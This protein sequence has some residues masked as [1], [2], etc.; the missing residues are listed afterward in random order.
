MTEGFES[1]ISFWLD[2]AGRYRVLTKA[3]TLE[4]AQVIQESPEGSPRRRKAVNKLV[5]HNLKLVVPFVRKYMSTKTRVSFGHIDT[6]D[7]LQQGAMALE[8]AASKFD[9]TRGYSFTTYAM[10]WIHSFVGRYQLKNS[11]SFYIPEHAQRNAYT[12][13]TKGVVKTK[14]KDKYHPV[15]KSREEAGMV[16]KAQSAVSLSSPLS[17]TKKEGGDIVYLQDI[18][19][20]R[21]EAMV[22]GDCFESYDLELAIKKANLD[23]VEFLAIKLTYID[24]IAMHDARKTLG[25]S[26]AQFQTARD[27]ALDKIRVS[28]GLL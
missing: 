25:M 13:D 16:R 2:N 19:P 8:R 14:G 6:L 4:I 18:V 11:S 10:P 1:T 12:F 26:R 22:S 9:P 20:G 17:G 15:E 5:S 28:L 23:E 27:S 21:H 24:E 7:Y 3:E